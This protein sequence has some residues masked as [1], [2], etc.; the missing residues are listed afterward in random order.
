M[1]EFTF[2]LTAGQIFLHFINLKKQRFR[3]RA[4]EGTDVTG[5]YTEIIPQCLVIKEEL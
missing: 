5:L 2:Y 4:D 3:Y 1:L